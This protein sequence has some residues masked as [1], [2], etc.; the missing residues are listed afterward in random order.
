MVSERLGMA[1]T[2]RARQKSGFG[3]DIGHDDKE[4]TEVRTWLEQRREKSTESGKFSS[5]RYE[6]NALHVHGNSELTVTQ[7][8]L[9]DQE[10]GNLK[11]RQPWKLPTRLFIRRKLEGNSSCVS[12]RL[13][14]NLSIETSRS[15]LLTTT[16][17]LRLESWTSAIVSTVYRLSGSI[18]TLTGMS[19]DALRARIAAIDSEIELQKKLLEKL[20]TDKIRVLHQL[21]AVVDPVA[22]FP[23]EISSEIFLQSLPALSPTGKQDV[24]TGLL[25]ICNAWTDIALS[26]PRLWTTVCIRFPCGDHCAEVLL[27]WF[28]RARNL[29]LSI[30][31][32]LRGRSI[33]WN[34]CVSDVL[35]GHGGKLQHLEILDDD[36][37]GPGDDEFDSDWDVDAF[38]LGAARTIDLFGNAA[39]LSLSLP[40]L[41]TL[42][43]RCQLGHRL[44]HAPQ[45]IQ[46]LRGAPNL[47]E[48]ISHK[49]QTRNAPDP[50]GLPLIFPTL[51]RVLF[52][53]ISGGDEEILL[54]L[55]LPALE[56]LSLPMRYI[57]GAEVVACVKRSTAPL[58]DLTIG[59]EV[60]DFAMDSIQL[61]DCLRLIPTLTRFRMWRPD[62]DVV[63][64]LFAALAGSASLLPNLHNLTIHIYDSFYD[65]SHLPDSTWR[66]LIRALS[67]RRMEQLYIVPV[68]ASPPPDVLASLRALVADGANMHVG[69]EQ[70]NYIAG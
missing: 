66:T 20:E 5:R 36:D 55:A 62:S 13:E 47:V 15:H 25:R 32:S 67:T 40:S 70:L 38:G 35:W 50:E 33:N 63:I 18:I 68:K 30:S 65:P 7:R 42:V 43:I 51:R 61:H 28:K 9:E 64:E 34:H 24:P 59:W 45:I 1:R 19:I 2:A 27:N 48:F 14:S 69:T 54:W 29:P 37:F 16:T 3:V 11:S 53:E 10:P 23:L 8:R 31:I 49:V 57:S 4:Y 52:G 44:Y 22:R 41:Q 58:Q 60:P 56:A 21:N 12:L 46:L 6:F 39:S 17:N 26:T